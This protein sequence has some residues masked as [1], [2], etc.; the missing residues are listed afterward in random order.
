MGI[1]PTRQGRSRHI[2]IT[3][4][5]PS[6]TTCP[7]INSSSSNLPATCCPKRAC[8][9]KLLQ[10]SICC[11]RQRAKEGRRR[12]NTSPNMQ[13][14]VYE[15]RPKSFLGQRSV[16]PNAITINLIRSRN[17]IFTASPRSS[18]TSSNPQ[19]ETR[20]PIRW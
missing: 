7:T 1:T 13:Q 18:P 11:S 17:M 4:S 19:S 2:G 8:N 9:S 6:M 5:S 3:S 15:T 10:V 14:I 12:R 16:A 20:L